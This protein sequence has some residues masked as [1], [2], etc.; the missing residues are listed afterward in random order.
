MGFNKPQPFIYAA[1]NFSEQVRRVGVIKGVRFI[2]CKALAGFWFWF[3]GEILL[4]FMA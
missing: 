3:L 4:R 1:R 2:N